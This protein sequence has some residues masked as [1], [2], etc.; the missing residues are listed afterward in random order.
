MQD[1]YKRGGAAV[2]ER[3]HATRQKHRDKTQ[4]SQVGEQSLVLLSPVTNSEFRT[5]D[6]FHD[7]QFMPYARSS[8]YGNAYGNATVI[9]T[10]RARVG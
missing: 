3:S 10:K 2:S 5:S 1:V 9:K 6:V 8:A 4:A 7:G